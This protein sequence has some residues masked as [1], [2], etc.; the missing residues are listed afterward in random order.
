MVRQRKTIGSS[1]PCLQTLRPLVATQSKATLAAWCLDYSEAHI[2]PL[3]EREVPG[4]ARPRQAI[5]AA[6]AWLAGAIK[7][8]AAKPVIL[9]CHAAAREAEGNPVAQAAARTVGQCASVIHSARHSLGLALYGA[10]AVALAELGP[11]APWADL[12]VRAAAECARMEA[13]LRAT[14]RAESQRDS[15]PDT[16]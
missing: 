9:A 4:D 1:A 2:L 3:Y 13:A 15:P 16:K 10:V 6:R 12:E 14:G 7:L 11:D 8:P 5:E